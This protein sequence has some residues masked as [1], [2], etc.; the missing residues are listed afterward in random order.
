MYIFYRPESNSDAW[1]GCPGSDEIVW[2]WAGILQT[3][4]CTV[5]QKPLCS[6]FFEAKTKKSAE[7]L[8]WKTKSRQEKVIDNEV[9]GELNLNSKVSNLEEDLQP[10]KQHI[11]VK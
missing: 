3:A 8:S 9:M 2:Q 7:V 11:S 6:R 1:A 10:L 4:A 5:L